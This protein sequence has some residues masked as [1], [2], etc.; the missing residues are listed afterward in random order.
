MLAKLVFVLVVFSADGSSQQFAHF[1]TMQQCEVFAQGFN[2]T[3]SHMGR[4]AC[5]PI[6]VQTSEDQRRELDRAMAMLEHMKNRL[7]TL[8]NN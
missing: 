2:S 1:E 8:Q 7:Q 4:A 3:N 6:N 5:L